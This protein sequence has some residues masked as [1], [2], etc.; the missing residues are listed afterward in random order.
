[1]FQLP[2]VDYYAVDLMDIVTL[3]HPDLPAHFGTSSNAKLPTVS[4]EDEEITLGHYFKR[5]K[6]YRVQIESRTINFNLDSFPT[7]T[8][9]ARLLDNYPNDPT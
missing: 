8:F 1:M 3:V 4:G 5:A 2:L 9:E 7:V 6:P